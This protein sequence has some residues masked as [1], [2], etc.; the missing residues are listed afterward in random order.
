MESYGEQLKRAREAKNLDL[1]TISRETSISAYYLEGLEAEDNG[2]FPGEAYML[3]F[4]R[5][6]ADYLGLKSEVLLS[7]Y[8]SKELQESPIPVG[9]IVRDKP[10]Y[11]LPLLITGFFLFVG[12]AAS[13]TFFLLS[14]RKI[15]DPSKVVLEKSSATKKYEL[16]DKAFNGRVYLGDQIIFPAKDGDIILTVSDTLSAFGLQCPV[17][18][19][20]TELSEEAELD[21]DGD[22]EPDLIVYLSDISSTD[23]SR[24]AEVRIVKRSGH[25]IS[26]SHDEIPLAS[27][28]SSAHKRTVIL[29]DNRAYPFT[30]NGNF[31][32]S[33]VFRYKIDR[34]EPVE[35]YFSSGEVVT[36]TANNGIRIWMSNSNAV[37]FT[38]TA[39]A[40]SY[41]IEIGRAGQVLVQDIKWIKDSDGRY[42]IMVMELD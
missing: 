18:K 4:L 11:F 37:K 8:R 19:L 40:R 39:D 27:D 38:V 16:S 41:D 23:S 13:L 35:S 33:C 29:D 6:Y 34:H 30:I 42:K 5:N 22:A 36:M 26:V 1:D 25:E 7:L 20:Y 28:V 24:G 12:L 31:R 3:G 21:I 32:G 10:G 2:V 17:G 15:D 9:L 14:H